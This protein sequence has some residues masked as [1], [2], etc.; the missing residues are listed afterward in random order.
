MVVVLIGARYK[1]LIEWINSDKYEGVESISIIKRNGPKI[2]FYVDT[3]LNLKTIIKLF[4]NRINEQGGAAYV[5]ELYGLYNGKV[6]YHSYV[7]NETKDTMRYYQT[8]IKD[9]TDKELDD[10][11]NSLHE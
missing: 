2:F 5:Y 4:K 11:F 3:K 9:L 7:S 8:K 1:R 6:D 10:Y